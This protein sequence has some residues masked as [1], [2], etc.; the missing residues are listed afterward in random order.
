MNVKKGMASRVSLFIVPKTRSGSAC[1]KLFW[2]RPSSMPMMAK[3]RP[4]AAS[5]KA[6]G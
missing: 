5:R 4:L 6:T 2:K 1:R 3:I